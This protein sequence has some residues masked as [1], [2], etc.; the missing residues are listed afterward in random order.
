M[1]ARNVATSKKLSSVSF[2]AETLYYRGL[3]FLDD[4]G[5][6]TADP[7]EFRATVIPM[8]KNGKQL[9]LKQ[10][11]D[12]LT[13]LGTQGLVGFC[14][15][16]LKR[17]QQYTNFNRF[18][19]MKKDRNLKIDCLDSNGFHGIPAD[20]SRV[21]AEPNLTKP[22]LTVASDCKEFMEFWQIYPKKIEK[23]NAFEKWNARLKE[24]VLPADLLTAARNYATAKAE[25]EPEFIKHPATFLGSKKPYEEWV[26][27]IP[28]EQPKPQAPLDADGNPL[29]EVDGKLIAMKEFDIGKRTGEI[30]RKGDKWVRK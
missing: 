5:V 18:Q 25:T 7:E 22:N 20:S 9:S 15:C 30:I 16:D 2:M 13:E 10:V 12:A 1:I 3:P 23:T 21:R 4:A 6:M 26:A 29:A 28:A 17:C 14:E 11:E 19:T 27:G 24:G 8:G